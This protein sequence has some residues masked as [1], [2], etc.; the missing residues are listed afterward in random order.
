M[1][2]EHFPRE[3]RVRRYCVPDK[4]PSRMRV[5]SQQERDEQ[6]VR[7]PESLIAL[8]PDLGMRCGIHEQHAEKH[9]VPSYTTG[10]RIVYFHRC[11]CSYLTPLHIEEVY[12][13]ACHVHYSPEEHRV[14]DLSMKPLAFVE[15]QEAHLRSN[16][17]Q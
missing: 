12:I 6:V 11:L 15:R 17:A 5:H 13:V 8:L 16:V 2:P 14:G 1:I 10:L 7:V 3:R 9:D 4:A